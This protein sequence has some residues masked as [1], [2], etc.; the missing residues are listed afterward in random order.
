M[1]T[2][3]TLRGPSDKSYMDTDQKAQSTTRAS[4]IT[5]KVM[6]YHETKL[7][8]KEG[9]DLCFM[10]SAWCYLVWVFKLRA[11]ADGQRYKQ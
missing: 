2:G 5:K 3:Y 11:S 9:N 4:Y 8:Y 10:G 7:H 1:E 6:I